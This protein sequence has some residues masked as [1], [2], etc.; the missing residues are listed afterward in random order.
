MKFVDYTQLEFNDGFNEEDLFFKNDQIQE[1]F[2][3]TINWNIGAEFSLPFPALKIR[4]GFMYHPSPYKDDS[5]KFDKKY[6]T[7]GI[8]FPIAK[9][10][11]FDFA[12]VYG[13]WEDFGD[14]YGVDV[15][16]TYQDINID[17][18]VFSISYVFM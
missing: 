11:L 2:T 6:V 7:G 17:K 4:G 1:L 14:N 10:L 18:M 13:W 9:R 16:R 8:G 12:Y 3:S 5:S 15:S